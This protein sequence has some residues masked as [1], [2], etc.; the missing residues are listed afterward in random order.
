MEREECADCFA[1]VEGDAGEW[2]CD[3]AEK[4]VEEIE[5]CPERGNTHT[6]RYCGGE[7]DGYDPDLLCEDCRGLFGH[8]YFSE[9]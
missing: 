9:L 4:T 5:R 3:V 8:T 1:L 6:C 7:A 2:V